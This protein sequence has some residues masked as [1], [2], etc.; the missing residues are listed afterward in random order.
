[1]LF[2]HLRRSGLLK[3]W[4]ATQHGFD[5]CNFGVAKLTWQIKKNYVNLTRKLKVGLHGIYCCCIVRANTVFKAASCLLGCL[6]ELSNANTH[7]STRSNALSRHPGGNVL[8]DIDLVAFIPP[9]KP[10]LRSRSH[11]ESEV[12][13][14]RPTRIPHIRLRMFNWII[15]YVTHLIWELLLKWYNFF[16]NFCWN[17]DFLLCTKISIDFNSQTSFPLC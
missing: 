4:V 10:G 6:P 7:L 14:W 13:G 15:F 11:K 8:T 5:K 3:L 16:F 2:C 1:M 17:R 9:R 12:F